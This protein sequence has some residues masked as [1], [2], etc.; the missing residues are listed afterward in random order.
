MTP[1]IVWYDFH[2]ADE[3]QAHVYGNNPKSLEI[4]MR[5]SPGLMNMDK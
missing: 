4:Y 5:I 3:K 1:V 2:S